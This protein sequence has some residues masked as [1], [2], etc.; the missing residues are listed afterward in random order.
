MNG[1]LGFSATLAALA[2]ALIGAVLAFTGGLRANAGQ[3]RWAS[4]LTNVMFVCVSIAFLIMEVALITHDFSVRYVAQVGSRATPLFFTV[5]SLWSALEGS[6]LLWAFLLAVYSA[7]FVRWNRRHREAAPLYPYALGTL[8]CVNVFFLLMISGPANPWGAVVPVPPDGPGPNPLLQNHPF[9][10]VHPPLLY[11]GY[12]GMAVPFSFA[13]AALAI[14]RIDREW[15][16]IIRRWVLVPWMFLTLGI[17]AGAWW[18]YE[19]LGWGGY[20]AW[21]AVENA[22]FMPWLTATAF[23]HSVMV[24]ERRGMLKV[25]SLSLIVVT[26]VLTMLGTFLTRSGVIASVHSFTQ[27]LVGPFFLAFLSVVLLISLAML[28]WRADRLKST[29]QMDSPVSRELAFLVNNLL[30][31]A[32]TFV[33]LVGTLFPLIA[34]AVRGVKVSVGA[35]FFDRM[36]MPIA[37]ALVVLSGV[38]PALPWGRGE[39]SV[40]LRKF[41]WPGVAAIAVGVTLFVVGIGFSGAWLTFVA[42]TFAFALIIGEVIESSRTR[43]QTA[44]ES[45]IVATLKVVQGNH[46][47]FGG[48]IVHVGVLVVAVGIA[49]STAFKK[50]SE[51]TLRPGGSAQFGSYTFKLDSVYAVREPQ[52]DGVIAQVTVMKG[53]RLFA[54][55]QPRMNY[56]PTSMDPIATP[57]VREGMFGDMYLVLVD[58]AE[59]GTHASIRAILSPLVLWIWIGGAG[60]MG[61]GALFAA[62]PARTRLPQQ[63]RTESAE[64][65]L[66]PRKAARVSTKGGKR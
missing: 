27:S 3:V 37:L 58:Y 48:Y 16:P 7:I 13:I 61:L 23:M 25:W 17:T 30:F 40:I 39:G 38:G 28:A 65:A 53:E 42:C 19:V 26:F 24:Q 31:A 29:G 34:E 63:A 33:V 44:Q 21:D 12:V 6:I 60:I 50:E 32:F 9:M 36:T 15:S 35:P 45:F 49:G 22:S 5:V 54:K 66:R 59:D 20:W 10:G 47:R 56:Y 52:R 41:L 4:R 14:G 43:M 51:W 8:L 18:S 64:R 2:A 55:L 57:A 1:I 62:W 11:T 46:R